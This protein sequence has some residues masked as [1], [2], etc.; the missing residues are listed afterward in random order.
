M[1][2][3]KGCDLWT[4]C[5]WYP[6]SLLHGCIS[7][8]FVIPWAFPDLVDH[9]LVLDLNVYV[10]LDLRTA[11]VRARRANRPRPIQ[12]YGQVRAR[13]TKGVCPLK[14]LPPPRALSRRGESGAKVWPDACK[15]E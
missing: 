4:V 14:H 10:L 15:K 13:L 1:L 9:V 7:Y 2:Q 12:R 6:H 5:S 8:N 3:R 11:A